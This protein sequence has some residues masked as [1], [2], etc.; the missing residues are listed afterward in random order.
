M[1]SSASR[2]RII[3]FGG[4]N[5]RL[6]RNTSSIAQSASVRSLAVR[7]DPGH[8]DASTDAAK[9][10][11]VTARTIAEASETLLGT[12][13]SRIISSHPKCLQLLVN[14]GFEPLANPIM[15]S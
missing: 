11:D 3:G 13:V 5:P 14:G 2:V 15:R 12:R 9:L 8:G 1:P 10:D 7:H 4:S 6:S